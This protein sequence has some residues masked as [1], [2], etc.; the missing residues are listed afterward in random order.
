MATTTPARDPEVD[1]L[2]STT[3]KHLAEWIRSNPV[4]MPHRPVQTTLE[5]KDIA[6]LVAPHSQVR[7]RNGLDTAGQGRDREGIKHPL[8]TIHSIARLIT[9]LVLAISRRFR[10]TTADERQWDRDVISSNRQFHHF[11]MGSVAN[12]FALLS[13]ELDSLLSE[14]CT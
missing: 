9:L 7:V 6:M 13:L 5:V 12:K 1:H 3:G 4:T 11:I 14:I 2:Q 10:A 8:D